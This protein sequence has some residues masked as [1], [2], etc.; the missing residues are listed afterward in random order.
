MLVVGLGNP[1]REYVGTRHNVGRDI[2]ASFA[3][4]GDFSEWRRDS[5]SVAFVA[6]GESGGVPVVVALPETYMN[7]SGEAVRELVK[8]YGFEPEDVVVVYDD[9]DL[10][11]GAVKISQDRGDGGHNGVK[12]IADHLKTRDFVRLRIGICPINE[13]GE[14]NKPPKT[15]VRDYVLGRFSPDE[16]KR[17]AGLK[18]TVEAIIREISEKGVASAMNHY[19]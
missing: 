10:P 18:T 9:I 11:V 3:E 7:R 15:V 14:K 16:Q 8:K 19:N 12:S 4:G 13:E 5:Y 2:I 17:I 1:G 6:E